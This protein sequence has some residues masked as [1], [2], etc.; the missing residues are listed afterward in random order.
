VPPPKGPPPGAPKAPSRQG[1]SAKGPSFGSCPAQWKV[2]TIEGTTWSA[3]TCLRKLR[4]SPNRE[5]TSSEWASISTEASCG[6]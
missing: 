4:E 1:S 3:H 6:A 2:A 5:G